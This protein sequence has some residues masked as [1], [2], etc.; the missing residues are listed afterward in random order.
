MSI[1][2]ILY[3]FHQIFAAFLGIIVSIIMISAFPD[4]ELWIKIMLFGG[5][6]VG[7][8]SVGSTLSKM[9]FYRALYETE[10]R[11]NFVSGIIQFLLVIIFTGGIAFFVTGFLLN[12]G[13][14]GATID[15]LGSLLGMIGG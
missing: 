8:V 1:R 7:T 9:L 13:N 4:M 12:N 2:A 14:I 10:G 3:R 15:L 11:G 6:V 5:A